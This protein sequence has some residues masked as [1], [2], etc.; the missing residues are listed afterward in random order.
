MELSNYT[1]CLRG[2]TLG[3]DRWINAMAAGT[4]LIAVIDNFNEL[5]WLPSPHAVPWRDLVITIPRQKFHE[6]PAAAIRH[7]IETTSDA[8]LHELQRVSRHYAA[9]LDWSAYH[10]RTLEN[11]LVEAS[12]I[13]CSFFDNKSRP[14]RVIAETEAK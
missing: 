10:S 14:S 4:A 1:L 13:P 3:S 7:V 5:D 12:T 2:D 8:R 6:D 9:D 11:M